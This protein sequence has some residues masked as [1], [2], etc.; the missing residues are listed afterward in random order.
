MSSQG[1]QGYMWAS[2]YGLRRLL[3]VQDFKAWYKKVLFSWMLGV[4][5]EA[6]SNSRKL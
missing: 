1:I 2:G 6:T 5:E 3:G 4:K